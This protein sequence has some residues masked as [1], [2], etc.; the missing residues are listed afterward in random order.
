MIE[1]IVASRLSTGRCCLLEAGE[2]RPP[3]KF[4]LPRRGDSRCSG[5]SAGSG[6]MRSIEDGRRGLA[7]LKA[8]MAAR[9]AEPPLPERRWRD[10][11]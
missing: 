6:R 5:G 9:G 4:S 10:M 3:R 8:P 1:A 7:W 2:L 11:T